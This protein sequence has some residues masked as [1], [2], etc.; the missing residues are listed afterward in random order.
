MRGAAIKAQRPRPCVSTLIPYYCEGHLKGRS[1]DEL[2]FIIEVCAPRDTAAPSIP[3]VW[4]F[5][6][7]DHSTATPCTFS[8]SIAARSPPAPS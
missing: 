6:S 7:G 5:C 4:S 1:R 2:T 3:G 8:D